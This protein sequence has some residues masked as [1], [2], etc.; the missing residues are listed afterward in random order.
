[1]IMAKKSMLHRLLAPIGHPVKQFFVDRKAEA[2][3]RK[4]LAQFTRFLDENRGQKR[5]FYLGVTAH[6]N[7]GDL[8][9]HYCINRWLE[10][11]CA[12]YKIGRIESDTVVNPK[13]GF[14]HLLKRNYQARDVIVFQSGYT[15]QDLG[16]NHDEM[17][18]LIA[19]NLPQANILMMPQTIFFRDDKNRERTAKSL[20]ACKNMVFL[21]RDQVSY[22]QAKQMF[23]NIKVLAYP[24]I[25]TSLIGSFQFDE[26]R[27]KIYICRRDDGEKYYSESDLLQLRD[28]LKSIAPVVMGDTES[29]DSL[30]NIRA[31]LKGHIV[32]EIKSFASYKVT[33]TDRYH[34]TIF[35]LC[36]GTPV[37]II[38]SNDHKVVTGADWFKGV[39]DGYVYVAKD[40]DDAYNIAERICKDT[41]LTHRLSPYFEE[42]YY[43]DT[44]RHL[45]N[46]SFLKTKES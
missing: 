21:A 36:A 26:L 2:N 45:F 19:D 13:L 7:L 40:M 1:M 15:T 30:Q 25:V 3:Q 44:L 9:Q 6:R 28:C 33:I 32:N 18:R 41:S 12:D 27:D 14:I 35:S 11:Y 8:A 23:P 5:I 39:Y 16:G 4:D 42:H 24:D 20:N 34:G 10:N 43:G 17:H 38:K 29:N 37:I 46:K 31:D 22:E